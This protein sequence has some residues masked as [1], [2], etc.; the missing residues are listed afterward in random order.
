[1]KVFVL[2]GT[3]FVGIHLARFFIRHGHAVTC[4]VRSQS[5]AEDLPPGARHV[6]GDPLRSGPWQEEAAKADLIVNLV[7]RS[8]MTRWTDEAKEAILKSRVMSTRMAVEAISRERASETVLVNANAVGYYEGAGDRDVTEESPAGKGFLAEVTQ[9]WQEE[10]ERARKK[11]ARVVIARFGAVLGRDGG[12]LAQML[13]VFQLGVGGRLGSGRQWFSWIHIHDLCRAVLF[14]AERRD[15]SG[16]VNFCSPHPVTNRELTRTLAR[17]LGRPAILPVPGFALR[18]AIGDAAK[19][20]LRGERVVPRVLERAG[21]AFE[22]PTIEDALKD[23][24]L[25]P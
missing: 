10:A 2:G 9:A 12:L 16:P 22:F 17:L 20:A 25:R 23:L 24:V 18:L 4:L 14:V 5:K 13:P 8:I 3:G 6:T 1:M 7:G 15:V 19:I 11:G 21:F